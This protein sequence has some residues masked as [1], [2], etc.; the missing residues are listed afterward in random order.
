MN[1]IFT[2]KVDVQNG[3]NIKGIIQL[4]PIIIQPLCIDVIGDVASGIWK[5]D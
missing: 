4:G 1:I 5:S 3:C 2:T